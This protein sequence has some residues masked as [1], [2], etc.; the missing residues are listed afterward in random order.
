VCIES[1]LLHAHYLEAERASVRAQCDSKEWTSGGR[2]SGVFASKLLLSYPVETLFGRDNLEVMKVKLK[3]ND[4]VKI[5][6]DAL[7]RKFFFGINNMD[8]NLSTL[9]PLAFE[10]NLFSVLYKN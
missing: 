6:S 1:S 4:W 3:M 9:L 7:K 2:I 5:L 8:E 10:G